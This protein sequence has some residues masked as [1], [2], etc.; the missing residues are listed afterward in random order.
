MAEPVFLW[1]NF[2]VCS[3]VFWASF[4][5]LNASSRDVFRLVRITHVLT[6]T[7]AVAAAFPSVLLTDL[8]NFFQVPPTAVSALLL[9]AAVLVSQLVGM[10]RWKH[11]P[12]EE[13]RRTTQC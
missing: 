5:R 11:G 13:T 12:P 4:C 9:A 7:A 2:I 10:R 8:A 3:A 1:V 6:L